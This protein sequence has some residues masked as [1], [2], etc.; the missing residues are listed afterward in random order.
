MKERLKE[1]RKALGLS[2]QEFSERINVAQSTYAQFETGRRELRDIHISQI[3]STFSASEK[4]LRTGEGEMFI[5]EADSLVDQL[6]RKYGFDSISRA[7]LEVFLEMPDDQR[8]I[9]MDIAKRLADHA[10]QQNTPD[11][12][13]VPG[14]FA[15]AEIKKPPTRNA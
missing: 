5:K 2:Q 7:L 10:K 15:A 1:L 14:R 6:C 3:C 11:T 13:A 4:W 8:K 12:P 9:I